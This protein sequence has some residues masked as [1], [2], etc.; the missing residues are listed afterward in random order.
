VPVLKPL[1]A[2][3]TKD[4]APR[5]LYA[6]NDL[7]VEAVI[8]RLTAVEIALAICRNQLELIRAANNQSN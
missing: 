7:T 2:E 4:C 5:Y 3:L 1:P 6:D 8:D